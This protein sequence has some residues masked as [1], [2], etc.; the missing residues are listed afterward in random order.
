MLF[1]ERLEKA[2]NFVNVIKPVS[3]LTVTDCENKLECLFLSSFL[4][5]SLIFEGKATSQR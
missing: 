4:Q 1:S 5:P 3:S 2:L